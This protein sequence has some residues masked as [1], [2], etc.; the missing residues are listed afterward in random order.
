MEN[1]AI[2]ASHNGSLLE[3][4]YNKFKDKVSLV[5]T[6]NSNAPVLKKANFY[7]IPNFVVN[8]KL[9]TNPDKQI[10]KLLNKYKCK[11]IFLA[12]YMKKLSANLTNNY[13]IINSHP[14]LLPKFGGKGMYGKF[15]HKA[16]IEAKE[17]QSGVTFHYVNENYDEGDIILQK[18]IK[19]YEGET[20]QE[21][22]ER[23]KQLEK[24]TV[25]EALNLCLK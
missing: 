23:I 16:V 24:E 3:T 15:V 4:I 25:I 13:N 9:Y 7:N 17:S 5:I 14:A 19:I 2:F 21:L 11:N 6:N 1:I 18:S 8:S 10:E 22:E 20:A 12:G